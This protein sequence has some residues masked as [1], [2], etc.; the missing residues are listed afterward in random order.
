DKRKYEAA[1]KVV[2]DKVGGEG[3]YWEAVLAYWQE[4][5][6]NRA[7]FSAAVDEEPAAPAAAA[8]GGMLDLTADTGVGSDTAAGLDFDLGDTAQPAPRK[9]AEEE[10]LDLTA[11]SEEGSSVSATATADEDILDVTAA[12][13]LETDERPELT[14]GSDAD[15]NVL[16]LTGGSEPQE[17]E[18]ILDISAGGGEDLLDVTAHTDLDQKEFAEDVLDVTAAARAPGDGEES[19]EVP[20]KTPSTAG[21]NSLDFDL[22][23]HGADAASGEVLDEAASP[24]ENVIEFES[25]APD[26]AKEDLTPELDLSSEELADDA[27]LELDL[28]SD[29][30]GEA[31]KSAEGEAPANELF[32]DVGEENDGGL[33]LELE[34]SGI[35]AADNEDAGKAP[36]FELDLGMEEE[37]PA[38]KA[39]KDAERDIDMEGTVEIPKLELADEDED[40]EDHTVF[41]PRSSDAPEQSAEDEIVTKLDLAKAYV[42]L[43]D[44]D[45]AKN[46]LD[47][48]MAAGNEQQRRQAQEL[49]KRL[50]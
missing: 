15:E 5:S 21:D 26:E 23:L 33:E 27:G 45:S 24:G 2:H 43:G 22:S 25:S 1:A 48:V 7:L 8:G 35:E 9:A 50:S 18:D 30:L 38:A 11:G 31:A 46:I 20:A 13:G 3:P 17:Q 16:D 28:S 42:E 4:M 29:V 14:A 37:V 40:D 12:V 47:E 32:L 10:V 49:M 39:A 34:G 19:M 36:E 41:V 44:K 6:P